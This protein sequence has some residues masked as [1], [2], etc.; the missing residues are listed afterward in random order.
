VSYYVG[1]VAPETHHGECG[2]KGFGADVSLQ[3]EAQAL[4]KI[5][6]EIGSRNSGWWNVRK[7]EGRFGGHDDLCCC[8]TATCCAAA[9]QA[10]RSGWPPPPR[11]TLSMTSGCDNQKW[12]F[13]QRANSISVDGRMG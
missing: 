11:H 3:P 12:R 10:E 4:T 13:C 9:S 6:A 1:V 5:W 8:R 7:R 2:A